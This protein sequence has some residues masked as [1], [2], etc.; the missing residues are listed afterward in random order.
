MSHDRDLGRRRAPSTFSRIDAHESQVRDENS[1]TSHGASGCGKSGRWSWRGTGYVSRIGAVR[2]ALGR[3]RSQRSAT[4]ITT[5]TTPT[6]RLSDAVRR[7]DGDPH[8]TWR[9]SGRVGDGARHR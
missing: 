5:A 2:A 9:V 6:Y 1:A 8:R 7:I 3:R 4:A